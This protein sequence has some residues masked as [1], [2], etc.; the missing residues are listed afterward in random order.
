M[1]HKIEYSDRATP[2]VPNVNENGRVRI[3][4]FDKITVN[5]SYRP[6]CCCIMTGCMFKKELSIN[7]SSFFNHLLT[8]KQT[9]NHLNNNNSCQEPG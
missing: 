4:W 6:T 2:I 8:I 9:V 3:C 7:E 5:T 1:I